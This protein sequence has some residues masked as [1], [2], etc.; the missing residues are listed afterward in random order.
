MFFLGEPK[1]A[2][3][4]QGKD[5]PAEVMSPDTAFVTPLPSRQL[6][7]GTRPWASVRCRQLVFWRSRLHNRLA[8]AS[9]TLM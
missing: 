2:R 4:A 8:G 9:R 3:D 6:C 7:K 1:T 5:A